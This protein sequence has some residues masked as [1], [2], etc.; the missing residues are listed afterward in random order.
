MLVIWSIS[1]FAI[2]RGVGCAE[3]RDGVDFLRVLVARGQRL[4]SRSI[5]RGNVILSTSRGNVILSMPR[6]NAIV[7][8]S[9]ENVILCGTA[10]IVCRQP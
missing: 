10:G 6:G 5:S 7:S 1:V 9:R 3:R 4:H 8:I 2:G